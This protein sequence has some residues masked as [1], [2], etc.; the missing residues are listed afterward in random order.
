MIC[1]HKLN[2]FVDFG[3]DCLEASHENFHQKQIQLRRKEALEV[4]RGDVKYFSE[5]SHGAF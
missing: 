5:K 2:H 3:R 4:K 1:L